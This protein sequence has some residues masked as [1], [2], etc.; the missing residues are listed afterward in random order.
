LSAIGLSADVGQVA[1]TLL[2]INILLGL[3]ISARYSPWRYW[4]HRRINIFWLHNYTGLAALCVS[5]LH[6]VI[7]LFSKTAGFRILDIAF[8][9]WAPKQPTIN[10]IGAG[11]LYTLAFVL[12]TSY[13]RVQLG[14]RAW[15]TL[16]FTTYGVA[17]FAFVH[18]ILAN[19]HLNSAPVDYLDGGKVYIEI[20][21]AIVLAAIYLRVRYALAKARGQRFAAQSVPEG[22]L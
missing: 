8:P 15:K 3:L 10:L 12:I 19:P 21:L 13:Y 6:P 2:S 18:S 9:A 7:I 1:I 11:A 20:C 16:H 14:R 22:T 17:G 4:P 5:V